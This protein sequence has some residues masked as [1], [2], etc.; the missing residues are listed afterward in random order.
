LLYPEGVHLRY[1][2]E[3]KEN[4][5]QIT[6]DDIEKIDLLKKT[7]ILLQLISLTF[8]TYSQNLDKVK[9]DSL[10][11]EI[12]R[13]DKGMGS[14]SMFKN[15]KEIYQRAYGYENIEKGIRA[16]ERQNTVLVQ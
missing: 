12:E 11:S 16:A 3:L 14:I 5:L 4:G 9:L 7:I 2:E 13:H 8:L 10:I 6:K 1:N 15:G